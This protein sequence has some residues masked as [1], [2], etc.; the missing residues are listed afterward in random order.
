MLPSCLIFYKLPSLEA[1]PMAAYGRQGPGE[2][3]E[4]GR[5]TD[6]LLATASHCQPLP[7]MSPVEPP[8]RAE[9]A[10]ARLPDAPSG[11][12]R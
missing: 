1:L 8:G 3:A 4:S 10:A 7:A 5:G 11:A 2:I 12:A 9:A 6:T